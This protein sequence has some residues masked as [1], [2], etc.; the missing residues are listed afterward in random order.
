MVVLSRARTFVVVTIPCE[1][2]VKS[3]QLPGRSVSV[4][5][6]GGPRQPPHG[7]HAERSQGDAAGN[8]EVLRRRKR[9]RRVAKAAE[10]F[11][12]F[13]NPDDV[14]DPPDEAN[15]TDLQWREEPYI[16]VYQ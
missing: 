6:C 4:A 9:H 1:R 16:I 12:Q 2:G 11:W 15:S 7:L 14:L 13:R 8:T 10:R 3:A 5:R